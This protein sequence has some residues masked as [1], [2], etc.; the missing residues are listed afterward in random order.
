MLVSLWALCDAHVAAQSS[1]S[2][3]ADRSTRASESP[4]TGEVDAP[5]PPVAAFWRAAQNPNQRRAEALVRQG[6]NQLYP[7]LGLSMLAGPDALSHRRAAV[8]NA[9]TRFE[10]ARKLVPR[11]PEVLYL[12]AKALA[13]WE[14]RGTG[15]RIEKRSREAI[16]RFEELRDVDGSYE[17]YQVAFELGILHTL[18]G[19]PVSA[20]DEYERAL[21][22]R[23]DE[24]SPSTVLSNLAEVTMMASDLERA[25]ELYERAIVAGSGDESILS[26]WGLSVALDRLGEH[27]EAYAQAQRAITDDQRPLAA[28]RQSGVFFV[29]FYEAYYYEGLGLFALALQQAGSQPDL[30]RALKSAT[31]SLGA[32]SPGLVLALKQVLSSLGEQGRGEV[33]APLRASVERALSKGRISKAPRTI[34][35]EETGL[36]TNEAQC[37][38][39]FAQSTRAFARFLDAGGDSGPWA[40]DAEAHLKRAAALLQSTN[41][42][43]KGP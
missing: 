24:G 37:I 1:D 6:R 33:F 31:R 7:A 41:K 30:E 20:A 13:L 34:M 12:S 23:I 17:A 10:L 32:S 3:L 16:A 26:R 27:S 40:A 35:S 25:V 4:L 42:V 5:S 9:I 14:R 38:L 18:E 11:D 2:A 21:S 22:L 8:E 28:L 39:S 15:G 36:D 19:D 29:P 43:A